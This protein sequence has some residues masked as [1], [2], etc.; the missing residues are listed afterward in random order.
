[1]IP[2][3]DEDFYG[4]AVHTA[5]LLRDRK[6]N[7]V[8]FDGIIEELEEMGSSNENQLINRLGIL[9]SHLLKW[10]FQHE[11]AGHSWKCTIKEQRNKI[12][13]LINKNPSL[14]PKIDEALNDGYMDGVILAS[15]DTGFPEN[16]FPKQCPYTFEQVIKDDFYPQ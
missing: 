1:M 13:R 8:D 10:Q 11:L 3:H 7:E 15:K 4:W 9:I 6:M 16:H 2:K 5:Q 14:K 12:K